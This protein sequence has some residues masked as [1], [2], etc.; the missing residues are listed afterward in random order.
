VGDRKLS[1]YDIQMQL[2]A[3]VEAPTPIYSVIMNEQTLE[4][5]TGG[6]G[7][8]RLPDGVGL[9]DVAHVTQLC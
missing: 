2:I 9:L 3:V 7:E 5:M 1:V 6:M 8:V 4:L